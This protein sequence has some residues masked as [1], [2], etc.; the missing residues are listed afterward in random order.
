MRPGASTSFGQLR[1]GEDRPSVLIIFYIFKVGNNIFSCIFCLSNTQDYALKQSSYFLK[2]A[3]SYYYTI[4]IREVYALSTILRCHL[5]YC[6][7]L[8]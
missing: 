6:I 8:Y 1:N 2:M 3:A 4:T 7:L 5:K